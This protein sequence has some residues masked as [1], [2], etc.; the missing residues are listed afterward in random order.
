MT[1]ALAVALLL[2]SAGLARAQLPAVVESGPLPKSGLFGA[3]FGL[4]LLG[5]GPVEVIGP[6]GFASG[7]GL[8]VALQF[9][10]G[11]R[12]AL[13]LP[14]TL[15]Y[16]GRHGDSAFLDLA[17]S[18][19]ILHRWRSSADQRWVPYLG[20]GIRLASQGV[21]RDF[22]GEPLLMK[23]DID[24]D[25]HHGGDDPNFETELAPVMPELW[26]GLEWHPNRWFAAN[27][28]LCY[29][30]LRARGQNV[31]LVRQ[32]LGGRFTF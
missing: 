23:L 8:T 1:R 15:D 3:G 6:A 12:W 11:P 28:G 16:A 29:S 9:D 7:V 27:L 31:Q 17:F 25:E 32:M 18:P 22:V 10:L 21:R 30:W 24:I 2:A 20:G 4:E 14:A 5:I 26:V 19:G 13:R